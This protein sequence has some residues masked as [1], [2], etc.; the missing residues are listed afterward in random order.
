MVTFPPSFEVVSKDF[1]IIEVQFLHDNLNVDN[2]TVKKWI[3]KKMAVEKT[4]INMKTSV[5]KTKRLL[6]RQNFFH[7]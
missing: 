5:K 1:T 7:L 2:K 4:R 6:P 3:R